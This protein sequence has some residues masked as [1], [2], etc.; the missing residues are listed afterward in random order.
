MAWLGV[1][2]DGNEII[3]D[4]KLIKLFDYIDENYSNESLKDCMRFKSVDAIKR[5]L[6]DMYITGIEDSDYGRLPYGYDYKL[7]YVDL[8]KGTI[9]KII[10]RELTWE[11]GTVEI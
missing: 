6:E 4:Y 2:S 9:K 7:E 1:D 8:P 10:G 5:N 11:D 3:S